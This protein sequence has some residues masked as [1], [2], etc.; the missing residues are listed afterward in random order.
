[1]AHRIVNGVR[2]E[3]T[4]AEVAA[5]E[6]SRAPSLVTLKR[7]LRA[8][9]RVRRLACEEA[10]VTVGQNVVETTAE[11]R[12]QL[13][14]LRDW[15]ADN[16]GQQVPVRLANGRVVRVAAAALAVAAQAIS[17][18]IRA[19]LEAEATHLEAIADLADVASAQAYDTSTGW[20]A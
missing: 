14:D 2:V 15:V 9:V 3:M 6:A 13:R 8:A 18:H 12:Q 17:A 4:A 11:F 20:P 19:C 16:P 1:M 5:L 10:G 7:D